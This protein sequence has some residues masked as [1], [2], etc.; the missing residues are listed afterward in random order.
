MHFIET[1]VFTRRLPAI[2]SDEEYRLLQEELNNRPDAGKEIKQSGGLRKIRRATKGHGKRGGARVIYYWI[3]SRDIIFF[4]YIYGKNEQG[5][6]TSD[7]LKQLRRVVNEELK[8]TYD[9]EGNV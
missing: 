5:D 4:L 6:L 7:Q 3:V 2:L 9:E 1:T 8:E